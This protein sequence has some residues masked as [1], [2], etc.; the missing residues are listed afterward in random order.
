MAVS[1]VL[2]LLLGTGVLCGITVAVI[3]IVASNRRDR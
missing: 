3:A 1:W 2:L